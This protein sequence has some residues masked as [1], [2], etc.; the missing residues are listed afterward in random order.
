MP[1]IPRLI[2]K[3]KKRS[4]RPFKETKISK[5]PE[6]IVDFIL[7]QGLFFIAIKNIGPG[8]AHHI[9]INFDQQ[10]DGIDGRKTISDLPLF[11]SIGFMPPDKE[12][13]TF[14]DKSDAYFS[15]QEPTKISLTVHYKDKRENSY[16]ERITHNL[17]I[18]KE[19]GYLVTPSD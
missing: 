9:S 17:A 14:L 12:I 15:R 18:Y 5:R 1:E 8:S 6:V 11:K 7:E 16:S 2:T 19:L 13:R 4:L 10:F 3:K